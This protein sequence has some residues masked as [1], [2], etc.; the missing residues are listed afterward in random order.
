MPIM[1]RTNKKTTKIAFDIL[2][3]PSNMKA[4]KKKSKKE[5][6]YPKEGMRDSINT[7]LMHI[8]HK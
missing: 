3:T 6:D 7:D 2:G 8:T 5:K 4:K 1:P